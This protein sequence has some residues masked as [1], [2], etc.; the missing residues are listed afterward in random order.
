[1]IYAPESHLDAVV[2]FLRDRFQP[3]VDEEDAAH[4]DDLTLGTVLHD[5]V[6]PGG[7]WPIP[8]LTPEQPAIEVAIPQQAL[9]AFDIEQS[10]AAETLTLALRCWQQEYGDVVTAVER[11]YRK[12]LRM[13]NA[14]VR[15]LSDKR[16]D[17]FGDHATLLEARSSWRADPTIDQRESYTSSLVMVLTIEGSGQI[18]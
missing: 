18:L 15:G 11:V 12:S 17:A 2:A 7:M 10:G 16:Q 1:M 6:I 8:T 3:Y 14:L 9:M 5:N 4:A 13:Q